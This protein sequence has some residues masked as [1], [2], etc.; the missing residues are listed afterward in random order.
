MHFDF[1]ILEMYL[2]NAKLTKKSWILQMHFHG[3]RK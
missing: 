2:K 1:G 3:F